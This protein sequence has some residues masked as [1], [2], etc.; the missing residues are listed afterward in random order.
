MQ[1]D[2]SNVARQPRVLVVED[3]VLVRM[4]IAEELRHSGF[5]VVEAA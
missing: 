1:A 5:D 4:T 3:E 2:G